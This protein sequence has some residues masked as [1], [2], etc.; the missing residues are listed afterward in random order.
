MSRTRWTRHSTVTSSRSHSD[1]NKH[2]FDIIDLGSKEGGA[3]GVVRKQLAAGTGKMK[4]FNVPNAPR[5]R[6]LAVDYNDRHIRKLTKAGYTTEKVNLNHEFPT[7]KTKLYLAFHMLEHL[8]SVERSKEVLLGMLRYATH[9]VWLRLPSFEQDEKGEGALKPHGLQWYWTT[10]EHHSSPFQLSHVREVLEKF[11]QT[12]EVRVFA[13]NKVS[14]SSHESVV[15][16][17][18]K[19]GQEHGRYKASM[20]EK[21]KL[22]FEPQ[23]VGEWEVLIRKTS[24]ATKPRKCKKCGRK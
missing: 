9:G 15:P 3:I 19:P 18:K 17:P 2:M 10:W 23:L 16:F 13:R 7:H 5:K 21:P 1:R 8:S 12:H 6:C 4:F 24:T 14:D 20:G 11:P 22:K